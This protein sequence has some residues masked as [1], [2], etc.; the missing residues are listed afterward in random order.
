MY[1]IN[2][3]LP[4]HPTPSFL[5][6]YPYIH[7]RPFSASASL[8][9]L[10]KKVHQC[11]FSKFQKRYDS[12]FLFLT[13][14]TLTASRSIHVSAGCTVLFLFAAEIPSCVGTTS[15]ASVLLMDR[16]SVWEFFPVSFLLP[17]SFASVSFGQRIYSDWCLS[18]EICWDL[19][20]G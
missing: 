10:W 2:P 8:F 13:P 18:C 14:F 9:L 17:F 4:I 15:S 1:R 12:V 19:F 16:P 3:S 7:L 6:W 20:Y 5:P 11:L